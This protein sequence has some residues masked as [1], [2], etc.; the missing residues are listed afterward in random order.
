MLSAELLGSLEYVITRAIRVNGTYKKRHDGQTRAFGG[1]NTLMCGDFWQL[2][3]TGGT[4]LASNP[5]EVDGQRAQKGL[6][7]FWGGAFE[8]DRL[9]CIRSFW[10][11]TE[12]M[13]C[14]DLWYND[15]LQ[16]CR[17]GALSMNMYCFFHGL[18][19]FTSPC[20]PCTCNNDCVMDNVLGTYRRAWKEAF[21][22]GCSDMTTLIR[23][24][25]ATCESCTSA[26]KHRQR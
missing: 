2:H 22:N 6:N 12:V 11:L 21:L 8:D 5:V 1:V 15:F 24:S 9:D 20:T 13:R 18:P 10:Q 4:F 26:R 14:K 25:E 19:T 3:P 16:Q 17:Q 7:L 23:N